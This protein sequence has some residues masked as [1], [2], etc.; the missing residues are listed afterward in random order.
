MSLFPGAPDTLGRKEL[1]RGGGGRGRMQEAQTSMADLSMFSAVPILPVLL[2]GLQNLSPAHS[3]VGTDETPLPFTLTVALLP[4]EFP[5][6]LKF[7]DGNMMSRTNGYDESIQLLLFSKNGFSL[8]FA[9]KELCGG[10]LWV[11]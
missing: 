4:L 2:S 11:A 10:L 9:F 1:A 6:S 3:V 5:A 7:G 8:V